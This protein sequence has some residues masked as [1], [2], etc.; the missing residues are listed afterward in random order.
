MPATRTLLVAGVAGTIAFAVIF[1]I[2]A[3]TRAAYDPVRH[4]VSI[5]SLGEGGW[6]QIVN[7]VVGGAL[8]AGLGIGLARRWTSGP[9]ARWVPLLVAVAGVA[10]V[11]CGVFIPDPSL[12]YP[13]GTPDQLVT[14]LT[15]H[16][17]IHYLF[18]TT[19]LLALS[20]AVL[21]SLRR[22][23]ALGDRALATISVATV[24]VAV[25]GCVVVLLFGG[26]DP[27]QLVGLLER[28]GIYAG[29]AWLAGIGIL[30]LRNPRT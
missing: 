21:L 25:G 5:L 17:A 16:G 1:T 6:L 15:W 12:G 10:L 11:G 30:E 18:A 13:P 29:W 2:L 3:A 26:L 27:V 20:A 14:P 28:I 19:I 9:G 4:F 8:L 24:V 23:V 7:F 22:G